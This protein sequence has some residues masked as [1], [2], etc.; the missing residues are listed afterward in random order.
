[1]KRMT[2]SLL[3]TALILA[4]GAA[5][6]WLLVA[7]LRAPA[8]TLPPTDGPKAPEERPEPEPFHGAL[9]LYLA[10]P[11]ALPGGAA[12]VELTL[13]EASVAGADGKEHAFFKGSRRV[14]LQPGS[15]GKALSD[16]I[17]N[18]RWTR[19][20]LTF[21]P[22]ADL[23]YADRPAAPALLERREALFSFSA[24]VPV[25]RTLALLA[26]APLEPEAGDAGGTATLGLTPQA[27]A[28]DSFVLGGFMLSPRD[29]GKIWMLP[30]ATL[31]AVVKKDLGLD[32]AR[33]QPG[34]AGFLPA[35][36]IPTDLPSDAR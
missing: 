3:T 19:L 29:R 34:S 13:T 17:P 7:R 9:N 11:E 27:A 4:L 14:M 1:M 15:V 6:I 8:P 20:K 35:E 2:I 26:T 33:K 36:E 25:S 24:E 5:A 16:E 12:R 28:A 22:A 23:S 31:A 21:S 10:S 18:G 32:I 30:G